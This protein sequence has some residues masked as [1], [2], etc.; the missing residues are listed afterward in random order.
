V[1]APVVEVRDVFCVH[2]T[3]EGD[4]AALQGMTL[5]LDA[6][7]VLCVLGPSGAGKSTLLRVVSGLQPPSAGFVGVLGTDV[8]RI[9]PRRRARLRHRCLGL[10]TQVVDDD[11]SPDV[12]A[13]TSVALPLALRGIPGR[14]RR[15][16]VDEVLDAAGLRKLADA[17]PAELSGGERQRF[18][19]CAALVHR[20]QVLLADEPTGGLDDASARAVRELITRLA[21]THGTSVIIASHD[22]EVAATADRVVRIRDG[23]VVEERREGET[24]LVLD[25][26]GWLQ[27][28]AGAVA[29][30]GLRGRAHASVTDEGILL[31]PARHVA[32]PPPRERGRFAS[33]REWEPVRAEVLAVSRGYRQGHSE[34][35]VVDRLSHTFAPGR[36]T[37]VTGRSGTGK[38]TL[39]RLLGGLDIPTGGR[40]AIDG[41]DLGAQSAEARV[42][43]RR[44]RIGYAPQ[45]PAPVG[46]LSAVENITLSLRARGWAA[47]AASER[48]ATVL[49]EIGLAPRA[50]QRTARL[51]AGEAQRLALARALASARGLLLVDEPTSRLDEVNAV[52]VARMLS[53]AARED[54]QTVI[55][56][57]HDPQVIARADDVLHLGAPA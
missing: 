42:A 30:A 26:G 18:A 17:L 31:R 51:S 11:L 49:A 38:T 2:R 47:G 54:G 15:T 50:H 25:R 12:P 29:D 21:R 56:A 57:T 19:V 48:A 44:A 35:V 33:R 13:R 46:F 4:A 1:S 55:C 37:A 10:L 20:P 14:E 27:L 39:L 7:E 23:R 9:S 53:R 22:A 36:L 43:V 32:A 52:E 41:Q 16:R 8:G 40:V 34:R 5:Q 28:P 3:N 45:D 24:A 6:G